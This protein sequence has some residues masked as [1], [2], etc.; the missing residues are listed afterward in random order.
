MYFGWNRNSDVCIHNADSL[1]ESITIF[2]GCGGGFDH[3]SYFFRWL[4]LGI[5][6]HTDKIKG[7][8]SKGHCILHVPSFCIA[9]TLSFMISPNTKN[10]SYISNSGFLQ[11]LHKVI[12][13]QL[14]KWKEQNIYTAAGKNIFKKLSVWLYKYFE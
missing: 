12:L 5:G 4:D 3:S 13:W 2:F 6:R 14:D 9:I 7:K 1:Q 8:R 11:T 10:N